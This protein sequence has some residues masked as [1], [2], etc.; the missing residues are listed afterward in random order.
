MGDATKKV[1]ATYS[2]E[3][4]LRTPT[5]AVEI[6][7]AINWAGQDFLQERGR[8]VEYD[9]DLLIRAD[10]ESVIVYFEVRP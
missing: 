8:P 1:Q 7:K 6:G 10:E 2:H 5:N 4:R 3:Y 9:D